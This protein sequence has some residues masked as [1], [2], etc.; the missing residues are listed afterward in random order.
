M[1]EKDYLTI[2]KAKVTRPSKIKSY[3]KILCYGRK[4]RG[5]T[6]FALS[7]GIP[8]TLVLDPERGTDTMKQMNPYVWHI[9]KWEDIQEAYG[10][11]RT[12]K[13]SPKFLGLGPEEE[14]FTWVAVDGLTKLN[15]MALRYV[16]RQAEL[17][18]L[19]H[20]PGKVT[21]PMYGQSGE[22][23]KQMMANFHTLK[24]NVIYTA[25]ERMVSMDEEDELAESSYFFVPD[26]PQGV[27]GEVNSLV[28]VI[29]RIYTSRV[30]VKL[31]NGQTEERMQ[32]RLWIGV[33]EKY[34]TGYRSDF[35][36]PEYVKYP[37]LPKLVD[38]MLKGS[39]E[40]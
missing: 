38:L 32:R 35:V 24:M 31:K 9:Q 19:D 11:L 33:H 17:R 23:M 4:K 39:E 37:T 6:R 25:Q 5:K 12:G 29:G 20:R 34:D 14:P 21:Q 30:T 26:M 40:E 16:L 27:R 15:N 3:R 8:N 22:L 7:S 18:D 28:D 2:A 10:A 36:L 1:A 13:L